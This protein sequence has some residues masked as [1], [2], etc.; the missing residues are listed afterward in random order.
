[1]E[2]SLRFDTQVLPGHRI[3]VCAPE[4]PEGA[5]VAL[6]VTDSSEGANR[7]YPS[8]IEAAYDDLVAKELH[9]TLTEAEAIRLKDICQVIADID[10]L[11]LSDDIRV[12]RLNQVESV[13]IHLRAEIDSLPDS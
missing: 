10:R 6:F 4:L 12:E 5:R 7:R 11:T 1:M 2:T 3:E 9:S 13:L 8:I